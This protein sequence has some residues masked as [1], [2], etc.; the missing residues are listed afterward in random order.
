MTPD[1]PGHG[2]HDLHRKDFKDITLTTY[3]AHI[4]E[5]VR[6]IPGSIVLVGHSMGGVVVT[7]VAENIPEKID[8]LIYVTAFVPQQGGSLMDDIKE[9]A[10]P[11]ISLQVR[12][13]EENKTLSL[14][15]SRRIREY[16]YEKC[17]EDDAAYA[18]SRLQKQPLIPFVDTVS[19]SQERF[20]SVPKLY[21]E[22]L[23]D[24]AIM[25]EDQRRMYARIQCDVA[26]IDTDHS[27]FFSADH[28]LVEILRGG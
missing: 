26:S 25:L 14:S 12:A 19:I 18:L 7:Q 1:L 10:I 9:T 27:P 5:V 4:E 20:G 11:T 23:Q 17:T 3:V 22:C 21:I 24:K 8:H 28:Q 13:D 2:L 16:L 6:K 15:P